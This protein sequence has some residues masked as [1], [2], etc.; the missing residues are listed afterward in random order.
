MS[1][2]MYTCIQTNHT[3][4][5]ELGAYLV[6]FIHIY[7]IYIHTLKVDALNKKKTS[8]S[9]SLSLTHTHVRACIQPIKAARR[10]R[11]DALA[12][13][14]EI[15]RLGRAHTSSGQGR[16][17]SVTREGADENSQKSVSCEKSCGN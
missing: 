16:A 3:T 11:R 7:H 12:V 14:A 9:L 1:I 13:Q 15:C 4:R 5:S 17:I 10:D 2:P 6:L 8:L